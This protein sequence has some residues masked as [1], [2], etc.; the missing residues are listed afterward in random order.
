MLTREGQ[1][2]R[3]VA[4][5]KYLTKPPEKPPTAGALILMGFGAL[6]LLLGFAQRANENTSGLPI[7]III[8]GIALAGG[9]GLHL[10]SLRSSYKVA[11]EQLQPQPSDQQVQSWLQA[12]MQQLV[13]HSRLALNLNEA[14]GDFSDP[15]VIRSPLLQA[16]E[17]V[18]ID[19]RDLGLWRIG[20]DGA[21][22]FGIYRVNVLWL[23]DRH[24]ASYSCFYNFLRDIAVNEWTNEIHYCDAIS[25]ETRE[26]S[27]TSSRISGSLPTG[28][29]ATVQQE[30]V[31][32]V[33][34]GAAVRIIVDDAY[35]REVTGAERLPESGAERA[36][37]VI[38]AML[39]DKKR[40][41]P[42]PGIA[43]AA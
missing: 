19:S 33:A 20:D 40:K 26:T 41:E 6:L 32:S 39:R 16:I 27:S 36:V 21:L 23:T 18:D 13:G 12:G 22:R 17:G 42:E 10:A 5:R 34:S 7:V 31:L 30:L 38:R 3:E 8:V 11:L 4:L 24:L 15:L 9:G 2:A 37:T 25:L 43:T 29:K 28:L 35:I 14:E 1:N